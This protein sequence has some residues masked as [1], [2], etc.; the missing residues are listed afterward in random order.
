PLADDI[1]V[2]LASDKVTITRPTG[3]TLSTASNTMRGPTLQRYVL[4][5]QSWGFDRQANFEERKSAL[6]L[7]AAD[8]PEPQRFS[9]RVDLARFYLARDM[10]REAKGVLDVALSDR[11]PIPDDPTAL[12]LRGVANVLIGR[13]DAALKDL[14]H[15]N[16]GNQYDAPLWRAVARAQQGKW[17]DAREGFRNAEGALGS[18]PLELQRVIMRDMIRVALEAG[19]ATGAL[20]QYNEFESLG[21]PREFEPTL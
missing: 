8:A 4:N 3:L 10:A 13:A 21:A 20:S 9:A 14:A 5:A 2:D 11:P 7:A 12:V 6:M 18:L 19:D 16:V 17:T 1:S 15:P